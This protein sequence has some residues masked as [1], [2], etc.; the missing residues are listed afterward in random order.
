MPTGTGAPRT[1]IV[2]GTSVGLGHA[3]VR[4]V[5]EHGERVVATTR[6]PASLA[7]LAQTFGDA[8]LPLAVDLRA[9]DQIDDAIARAVEGFGG[10]DV[11]VYNAGYALLGAVEELS[12]AELRAQFDVNLFGAFVA[13][14]AALP[15][16]RAQGHGEMM[17]VSSSGRWIQQPLASGYL[18]SKH[19]LVG[20]VD[21]L[22][23]EV[24]PF[25][26]RARLVTPGEL[27]TR[28]I[29]GLTACDRH[30]KAYADETKAVLEAMDRLDGTQPG[31]PA[32]AARVLFEASADASEVRDW[33]VLGSDASAQAERRLLRERDQLD[34]TAARASRAD[35]DHE[36]DGRHN[37]FVARAHEA[38]RADSDPD[39]DAA[40]RPRCRAP[41]RFRPR[42]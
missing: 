4:E 37:A 22:Q 1:W 31:D 19:A 29:S 3:L 5:L 10:I 34:R 2:L 35:V 11:L 30:I 17:F 15:H 14:R 8:L 7:D 20:F 40:P 21:A 25:G 13:A 28:F 18:S 6:S 41:R 12:D 24:E 16:M 9:S 23:P 36:V 39:T 42:H 33:V 26:I 38:G 27:R 32:R